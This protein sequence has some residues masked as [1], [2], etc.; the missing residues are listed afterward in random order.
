MATTND[1]RFV[2]T[3]HR[4]GYAFRGEA[5]D[6]LP[7]AIERKGP[8]HYFLLWPGGRASLCEGAHILGRD[9]GLDIF[10]DLPGVSRRHAVIT[11]TADHGAILEDLQSKNGTF[12][13][14]RRVLDARRWLTATVCA[15]APYN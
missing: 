5:G 6:V 8:A 11:I 7:S 2:R 1:P 12:V 13:A 10:L 15:S 4:F 14:D 9:P 3:V